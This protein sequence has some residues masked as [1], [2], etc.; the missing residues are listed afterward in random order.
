MK[1]PLDTILAQYANSP[2]IVDLISRFNDCIDPSTDLD[3]LFSMIWDVETA[4][5]YGLDVWGK[6]VGVTRQLQTDPGSNYLGFEEGYTA[7]TADT[8]PQPFDQAP[9]YGG[10]LATHTYT[11]GDEAYRKL[12]M[13]KAMANITDCT[14]PSLNRLLGYLFAGRGRAYV[15][16]AGDMRVQYVFE[17]GLSEVERGILLSS[18]AVPRPAGVK[19]T[20][21]Q[22]DP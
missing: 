21:L 4:V 14:A 16:D 5:G 6:I 8:G 17:F 9:F 13:T 18:G 2:T 22:I 11:L 7:E 20:V 3:A 1:N 12:I 15:Q 10:A 19:V